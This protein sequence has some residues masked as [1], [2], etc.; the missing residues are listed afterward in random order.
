MRKALSV[1]VLCVLVGCD[2]SPSD[3]N[4]LT[5]GGI[6]RMPSNAQLAVRVEQPNG[7]ATFGAGDFASSAGSTSV[8]LRTAKRGTMRVQYLVTTVPSDTIA[9]ETIEFALQDGNQY[10]VSGQRVTANYTP[11]CFGCTASK[12]APLRGSVLPTTD[13][14]LFYIVNGKPCRGCVY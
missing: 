4:V 3:T 6:A 12:K 11:I 9:N 8:Q 10:A 2:E 14:L 13:S 7:V 1:L 5:L